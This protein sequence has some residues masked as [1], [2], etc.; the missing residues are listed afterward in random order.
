LGSASEYI[1]LLSSYFPEDRPNSV[2]LEGYLN[3]RVLVEGLNRAGRDLTREGFIEAIESLSDFPLLP[4]T[5]LSFGRDDHKGLDQVNFIRLVD[6]SFV[7]MKDWRVI[8][9]QSG[10]TPQEKS[11]ISHENE[12]AKATQ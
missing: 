8:K 7:L 9:D 2:G 3:A 6:G 1:A 4:Y 10:R 5:T 12:D 11:L